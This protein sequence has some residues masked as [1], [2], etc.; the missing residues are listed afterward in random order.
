MSLGAERLARVVGALWG[1]P[2]A[3]LFSGLFVLVLG[4]APMTV[5]GSIVVAAI[6][7]AAGIG[8]LLGPHVAR[9]D[10]WAALGGAV[11]ASLCGVVFGPFAFAVSLTLAQPDQPVDAL[12]SIVLVGFVGLGFFGAKA[13]VAALPAAVIWV[14]LVRGTTRRMAAR[15]HASTSRPDR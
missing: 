1:V 11:L 13:V 5:P 4:I 14:L 8:W 7:V 9:G 15:N 12:F 2:V 6:P 3:L 10:R